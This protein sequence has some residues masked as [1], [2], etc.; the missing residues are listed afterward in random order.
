M[1]RY[2]VDESR[3]DFEQ[4]RAVFRR[5]LDW[6]IPH[7]DAF[8]LTIEPSI[9]THSAQRDRILALSTRPPLALASEQTVVG[10]APPAEFLEVLT[11][12]MA[13]T[14]PLPSDLSCIDVVELSRQGRRFYAMFDYGR[15]QVLDLSDEE[16]ADLRQA[17]GRDA[18][19]VIPA[20]SARA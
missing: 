2:L 7:A 19:I 9:Y 13:V 17:L 16:V 4:S 12:T 3:L 6:A 8:S 1:G 10:G 11:A 14:R 5:V 18:D 15:T 20:P